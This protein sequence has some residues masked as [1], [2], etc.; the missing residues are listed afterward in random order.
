MRLR[1]LASAVFAAVSL[2]ACAAASQEPTRD[3]AP[4]AA[5]SAVERPPVQA[6]EHLIGDQAPPVPYS[7]SP[8]TSGWHAS[9]AFSITVHRPGNPLPEP[10]QVSVLEAGGV[11][12]AYR[13][14]P[15]AD[16]TAL[17]RHIRAAHAGRVA[18]T[19]YDQLQPGQMAFT[20]WGTLQRCDGLDLAALD[21]FVDAYADKE[22][23][24]PGTR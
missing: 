5:C 7:S 12:V 4:Q 1:L 19:P 2:S 24:V 18:V 15:D 11:V 17:E 14:L 22:P 3:G 16:R 10:K 9:G 8:P 13:Q 23:D 21:A 20:A 6:G